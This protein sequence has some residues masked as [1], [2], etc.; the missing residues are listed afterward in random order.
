M[1]RHFEGNLRSK[2]NQFHVTEFRQY[3][4]VVFGKQ[5]G[6]IYQPGLLDA[7]T[8]DEFDTILLSLKQPWAEREGRGD[9]NSKFHDWMMERASMMRNCMTADVRTKVGLGSPPDKFYTN[10]SENTNVRLRHKT[11]GKEMGETAFAKAV[12]AE[13][14]EDDQ[15]AEVILA[16]FGASERYELREQFKRFQLSA[17][18]WWDMNERQRKEYVQKIYDLFIDDIYDSHQANLLSTKTQLLSGEDKSL[19]LSLPH[20]CITGSLDLHIAE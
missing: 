17:D 7:T 5:E 16:L 2:L 4:S 11:Q 1:N 3:L 12:K 9:G 10:D 14:I 15:E 13:M 6:R 19:Q 18:E 20:N 8:R